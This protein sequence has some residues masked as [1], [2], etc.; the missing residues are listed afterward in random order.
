VTNCETINISG[1]LIDVHISYRDTAWNDIPVGWQ[2]QRVGPEGQLSYLA[3][4]CTS[5]RDARDAAITY[6]TENH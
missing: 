3:C 1:R 2:A 4:G 5:Y 6:L